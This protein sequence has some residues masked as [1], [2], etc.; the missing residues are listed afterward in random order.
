MGE[1]RRRAK[2]SPSAVSHALRTPAIEP[3]IF[4]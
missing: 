2:P 4:I 3:R 1:R